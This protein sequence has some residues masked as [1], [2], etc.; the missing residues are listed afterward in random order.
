MWLGCCCICPTLK[1]AD[2]MNMQK[3]AKKGYR[4][5]ENNPAARLTDAEV[6]LLLEMRETGLSYGKLA[7]MF[8][9][10]KSTVRDIVKG[11]YR[12]SLI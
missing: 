11:R 1:I 4:L 6:D 7:K 8:E 12:S 10:G 3:T 5:G 9:V 2:W